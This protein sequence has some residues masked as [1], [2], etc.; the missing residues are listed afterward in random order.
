MGVPTAHLLCDVEQKGDLRV[1]NRT[2]VRRNKWVERIG[3]RGIPK[4]YIVEICHNI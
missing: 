4:S 3:G 1:Y 2:G